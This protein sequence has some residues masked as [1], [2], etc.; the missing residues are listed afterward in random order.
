MVILL[1]FYIHVI[2]AV[3]AFTKRWQDTDWKEGILA[4]GFVVLIFVVGWQMATFIVKSFVDEKGLGIWFDRDAMALALL[5]V[6]EG[7]IYVIQTRRKKRRL[8]SA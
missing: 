5:T 3:T 1:I 4:V 2:A 7:T 6:M 8:A